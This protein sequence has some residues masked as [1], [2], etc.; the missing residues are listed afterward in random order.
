M[1]EEMKELHQLFLKIKN[2]KYIK[3]ELNGKS[4]LGL[5][6]ENLIGKE[7]DTFSVPDFK[8]IEIKTKHFYSTYDIRLFCVEP[9]GDYLFENKRLFETYSKLIKTNGVLKK[10]FGL[11][12]NALDYAL[13]NGRY[14][15][16]LVDRKEEKIYLLV[17]DKNYCLI[18][19]EV[20]WSFQILKERIESKLQILALIK[21]YKKYIDNELYFYYY[22]LTFYKELNFEKFLDLVENGKISVGFSISIFDKGKRIGEIYNHGTAF[23]INDEYLSILY[24]ETIKRNF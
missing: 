13:Y 12:C 7:Q 3:N 19:K 14:F 23:T 4:A 2:K 5:T 20:S 9:D 6:F 24:N 10:A 17:Y 1:N 22:Y 11:N 15:K 8:G 16:L 18:E 21:A